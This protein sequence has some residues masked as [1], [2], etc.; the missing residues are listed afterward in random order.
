MTMIDRRSGRDRRDNERYAVNVEI[1]WESA[2][3][4]KS[5]TL[6]DI[7]LNGCFVLSSGEVAE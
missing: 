5:G 4:R 3:G 2:A 1:E 6:S 7:G